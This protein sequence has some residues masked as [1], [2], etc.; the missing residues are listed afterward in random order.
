MKRH[1]LSTFIL[2]GAGFLA[3]NSQIHAQGLTAADYKKACWMTARMYGGQRSGDGPNWLTMDHTPLSADL[4]NLQN[5]K[6]AKPALFVKG[7]DFTKDADGTNSLVGGWVDCGDH[8]KFGQTMFYAAYTLL[9]GYAEFSAGYDDLYTGDYSDYQA[10]NDFSYEG[11]KGKPNGIPDIL[12]EVKYE[13]DFFIRCTPDASTFYSQVGNG[14]KD[15]QNWVTSPVMAILPKDQG[16]QNDG[17]RAFVKNP[18][19]ASMSS[20]CASTL[21]LMARVY[22]KFDPTYAAT[23]LT[24]AKYAYAYAKAHPGTVADGQGGTYYPANKKWEDDFASACAELYW[25]TGEVAYKNE[26]LSYASKVVDHNWCYNYNNNDDVAAYNLAKLGDASMKTLLQTFATNYTKAVS[27]GIYSGGDNSWGV[28]RYPANAAFVVA[29]WGALNN[30]TTIDA[31]ITNQVDYILGKN[32]SNFSFVVGYSRANCSNCQYAK[33]PHHRNVYLINDITANQNSMVIPTHNVQQ[34]YLIGGSKSVPFSESAIDYKTSEGGIDYNAGLVGAIGYILSRMAPI[35]TNKFGHPSPQLGTNQSMCGVTSIVLDSKVPTDGKITYT[36]KKDGT[37][38]QAASTTAKTYTATAAGVYTCTIDS[39][40]K[41]STTGTVTITATL[42]DFSIGKD[43]V[44]CSLTSYTLKA[45]SGTGFSYAWKKNGTTISGATTSTYIAYTA[46]T[47]V[48]TISATG[49]TSKS[50]TAIITSNLPVVVNDTICKAGTAKLSV[51]SSG[52]YAWYNAATGGTALASG[53]SY[54]PSINTTAT[55]YLQDA[56]SVNGTAGPTTL[57]STALTNWGVSNTLQMAFTVGASFTVNSIKMPIS[58][59]Y[60]SGSGTVTVEILDANG[61]AFSP[62][63]TFTSNSVSLTSANAGTLVEF[64]FSNFN[65]DKAW[66]TS[67]RIRISKVDFQGAIGFNESGASYPYNSTPSG[68]MTITGAYNGTESKPSWFLYFYNWKISAGSTCSRAPVVAV[69]DPNSS[70]C[71]QT[72]VTPTANA[73]S[74]V[75]ICSG[76]STSLTATGGGS[77]LWSTGAN[78]ATITVSPTVTTIYTVTVTSATGSCS[79]T[80]NV[81]VTVN[82]IP[83]APTV[84]SPVNYLLNAASTALTATGT[85][86]K[87]YTVATAG[88][89]LASAPV[90]P[91]STIGTTNYYVSQ[92]VNT[93]ESPRATI[94]VIVS[95]NQLPT[96][97]ITAPADNSTFTAPAT[98]TLTATASDVDGSIANVKFYNGD[99]LLTTITTAPYSYSWTS[100]PAGID[101]ITAV[102]TDNSGGITTSTKIF[103]KVNA[104]QTITLNAGWNIISFNVQPSNMAVS[105]VFGSL[106]TNL[107]TVKNADAFYDP[108]QAAFQN[109]LVNI[110]NGKAYLVKVK[111]ATTLNVTGSLVG[112]TTLSLKSG[113]NL[114]GYPKQS[115][116]AISS[117]LSGIWSSFSQMKDFNGFYIKGGTLNSLSTMTPN[118]GYF[119]K[120]NT[121]CSLTY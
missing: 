23:C 121:D 55:Y 97:T 16:G 81:S 118:S 40:G 116:G 96:V 35:D 74:D 6:G 56:S 98:I 76:N 50:D 112:P 49:C 119:I 10:A 67:L 18:I 61:T 30:S 68:V 82:A 84:T 80:D 14:D 22:A 78:T 4:T 26:A 2:L 77:Y 59:I 108:S 79:A 8:V 63:K 120:V 92:T 94:A 105:S 3:F 71:S 106:G 31:F 58:N 7:K 12:D 60:N 107:L 57:T 38:V 51:T 64:P 99:S 54:S 20:L 103:I 91:T 11:G 73:G 32:S 28:L 42:P 100:V 53:D 104:S 117:V 48:C 87:W 113:W 90:P 102:A 62:A 72:C 83:S 109:S 101:T 33:H 27:G 21:A 44:L 15:H 37:T 24:H 95:A 47:Y 65:I 39:L 66:G 19:D 69:I 13:C 45:A 1:I 52:S 36:W 5:N 41:W 85:A 115:S 89:A 34:G 25:A 17:A 46:G 70:K 93:C 43:T 29:L 75:S 114:V 86:L 9:K 110:E 88:T 111:T